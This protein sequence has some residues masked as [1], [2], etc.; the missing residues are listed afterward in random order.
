[1]SKKKHTKLKNKVASKPVN[2]AQKVADLKAEL[3]L[4]KNKYD[5]SKQAYEQLLH[6][7]KEFQRNRFGQKSERFI[8][9]G[10]QGDFFSDNPESSTSNDD[11]EN[12]EDEESDEDN[13]IS[14]GAHIRRKKKNFPPHLPRRI[15]II[16]AKS[17]ICSCG[18]AKVLV[19][20]ETTE[21]LNHIPEIFEVIEQ[22]REVLA[23]PCGCSG[24]ITTAANPPR[25]LPKVM[26]TESLLANIIVSK[27]HD[28]QPLYVSAAPSTS[29]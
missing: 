2:M 10:T 9:D 20:Y 12:D 25:I 18:K 4:Y 16:E 21:L 22:K 29:N 24:S 26:V 19:R 15:E 8:D 1:M 3:D 13:V 14:I 27:F 11:S 17:R 6:H 7:F 23:C 5:Q 28:R